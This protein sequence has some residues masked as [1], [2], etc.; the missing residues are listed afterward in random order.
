MTSKQLEERIAKAIERANKKENTIVKKQKLI[1]KKRTQ[2]S[3]LTDEHEIWSLEYDAKY[4]E[5]D[6][7]RLHKEIAEIHKT[8]E[9]YQKQLAGVL[10][11]ENIYAKEMPEQ[12]KMLQAALVERWNEFDNNRKAYCRQKY[13]E[14]GYKEFFRKFTGADYNLMYKSAD[15]INKANMKNAELMIIDL[16]NRVKDITGEVTEW[17]GIRAEQGNAFPVLT[18]IVVGKMGRAYVE[19]IL[20]GGYN[21]QKLHIRTLVHS[22]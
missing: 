22:I 9:K 1:D 16:F 18:G 6:I 3:K 2:A 15:E 17:D 10:E 11:R 4:L 14:L 8:V 21:I 5:E 19:T 20:A 7:K 13:E 12:F